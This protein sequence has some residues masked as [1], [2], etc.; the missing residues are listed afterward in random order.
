MMK[1]PLAMVAALLVGSPVYAQ[2]PSNTGVSV[3]HTT[4]GCPATAPLAQMH[5]AFANGMPDTM[6]SIAARNGCVKILEGQLGQI[7]RLDG[8]FAEVKFFGPGGEL[9]VMRDLLTPVPGAVIRDLRKPH[10]ALP[11]HPCCPPGVQ[12]RDLGNGAVEVC[13]DEEC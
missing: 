3:W 5:I 2:Q 10:K 4:Y 8:P 7:V 9:W 1:L 12:Y 11:S 6:D 13:K